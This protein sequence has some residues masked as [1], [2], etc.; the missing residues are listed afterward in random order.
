MNQNFIS[1][2]NIGDILYALPTLRALGGGNLFLR[3]GI[4]ARY[5]PGLLHP[6]KGVRMDAEFATSLLPLLQA[7][8]YIASAALWQGEQGID[9]DAFRNVPQLNQGAGNLPRYYAYAHNV[10]ADL[11]QPWIDVDPDPAYSG[12]II[13]NRTMR[14][15]NAVID[16][17]IFRNNPDVLFVG[18]PEEWASMQPVLGQVGYCLPKDFLQLARMLK[19][20]RLF[21]GNQSSC[22]ALAEGIKVKRILEVYPYAPNVQPCNNGVDVFTQQNLV[23]VYK[24]YNF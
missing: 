23:K 8:P 3:T 10:W 6:L 13:I 17:S 22:Y 5:R 11:W 18:L 15:R 4:K 1:S 9:L 19:A 20:S 21:V 16:Y 2:G 14:Y 7:Q 24:D 12:A